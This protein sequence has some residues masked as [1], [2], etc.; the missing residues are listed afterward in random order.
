MADISEAALWGWL[1]DFGAVTFRR[2]LDGYEITIGGQTVR[3][4]TL[5]GAIDKVWAIVQ[6]KRKE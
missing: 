6:R 1:Y 5:E 4:K 3:A 2:V